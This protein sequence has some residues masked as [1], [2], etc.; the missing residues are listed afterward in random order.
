MPIQLYYNP[1]S[2]STIIHWML[3]ECGAPYEL[4]PIDLSKREQKAPGFLA[5]NPAGKL[6]ALVDGE[7]RLWETAAICLYLADRFA[8]AQLAI[9][10][11]SPER[12]RYLSLAVY[13]MTQL[14]PA[15]AD[16]LLEIGTPDLRGWTDFATAKDVIERELGAGPYLFGERF[17]AADVIIGAVLIFKHNFG[18]GLKRPALEAYVERLQARPAARALKPS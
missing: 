4:V 14:E 11:D 6:P 16:T 2:R 10:A 12:G 5:I 9:P 15:M 8:G 7:A 13:G 17:T 3:E 1:R 18:G